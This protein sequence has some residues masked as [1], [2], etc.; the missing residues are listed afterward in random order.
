MGVG[1]QCHAPAALPPGKRPG[2]HRIG[3]WVSPRSCLDRCEKSR[4]P[5]GF[6]PQAVQ[7]VASRYKAGTVR[8]SN[9]SGLKL[10]RHKDEVLFSPLFIHIQ[11]P[12]KTRIA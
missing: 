5:P 11:S 4:P 9:R 6:D 7:S 12:P 1:D 10:L 2:S 8:I 3:G